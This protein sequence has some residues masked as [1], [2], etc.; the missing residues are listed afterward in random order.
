MQ[1]EKLNCKKKHIIVNIE[2]KNHC[3]NAFLATD[4]SQ[5]FEKNDTWIKQTLSHSSEI[6]GFCWMKWPILSSI[7]LFISEEWKKTCKNYENCVKV[8]IYV[9]TTSRDVF[10]ND[11]FKNI[12]AK[13]QRILRYRWSFSSVYNNIINTNSR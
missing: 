1:Y 7:N 2:I 5:K 6:R 13:K 9:S 8:H 4:T 10:Q 3:K 12:T 11:I